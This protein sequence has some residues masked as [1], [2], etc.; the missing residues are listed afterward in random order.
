ML[1][2]NSFFYKWI[3][4]IINNFAA[5]IPNMRKFLFVFLSLYCVVPAA[6]AQQDGIVMDK[7]GTDSMSSISSNQKREERQKA[8][9][10]LL[11]ISPKR[12]GLYSAILPGLGQAMNHDY[13]K[14]PI[15]YAG[16]A[17]AAYYIYDNRK[18]YN[19][20]RSIYIGRISNDPEAFK[21]H[22]ELTDLGQIQDAMNYY[23]HYLDLTVVISV[24]GYALQ[25]MDA[26]VFANLKG[27]DISPDI[28]LKLR[29]VLY[30]TG[31][32]GFGLVMNF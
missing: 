6:K 32:G 19:E 3:N 25:I 18:N 10:S 11:F 2:R 22:P 30:P 17:V 23:R 28:S 21:R 27:F 12:T 16:A 26:V 29:P 31:G 9:Q 13:W 20:F 15:I 5:D 24:A 1:N 4:G 14:I 7:N 8:E